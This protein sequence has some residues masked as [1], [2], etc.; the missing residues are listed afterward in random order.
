[1]EVFCQFDLKPLIRQA[2]KSQR[3]LEKTYMEM[4]DLAEWTFEKID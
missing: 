1:M 4:V 2:E 3:T